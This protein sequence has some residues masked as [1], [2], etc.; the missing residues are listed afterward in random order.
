MLVVSPLPS[1]AGR[2]AHQAAPVT[3]CG[4]ITQS[5]N[6]ELQNDMVL[7]TGN[8]GYGAGGNC[9]VIAAPHTRVD[10]N[11]HTIV[12][13][14]MFPA[15]DG[16]SGG[17]GIDI[18]AK[19][20]TVSNGAVSNFVYGVSAEGVDG[21]TVADLTLRAVTGL[22]LTDVKR[23]TFARINY[24]AADLSGVGAFD[25]PVAYVTGGGS[26]TFD[27][28]SGTVFADPGS[29]PFGFVIDGSNRN[30]ISGLN[31]QGVPGAADLLLFDD[32]SNNAVMSN[33]F[34]DEG[35]SGIVIDA[36]SD[37]N[38]VFD[39]DVSV[40]SAPDEFAMVD[41][42]PD[43]GSNLWLANTFSNQFVPG[44]SADPMACIH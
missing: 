2:R 23:S 41:M 11:G 10:L 15:L 12:A 27:T 13:V 42:N 8:A 24:Q 30:L 37:R 9:L 17:I 44:D 35:G 39:N 36:G 18:E 6:Y 43:C 14:S 29:G 40:A 1:F 34:F 31:I 20:V 19:D 16:V 26:N 7:N 3:G 32:A 25:G 33:T 21:A 5:G 4:A 22:A 38:F 28:L